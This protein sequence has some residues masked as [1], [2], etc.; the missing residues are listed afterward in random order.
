MTFLAAG[1][2][3]Y[4]APAFFTIKYDNTANVALVQPATGAKNAQ[5]VLLSNIVASASTSTGSTPE[6]VVTHIKTPEQVRGIYMSQCVVG[7]RSF[8]EKLVNVADTTEV[9]SIVIDIKDYSGRIS[10]SS[11]NPAISGSTSDTCGAKDMVAFIDELHKKNIY[12]IGRITVFQDPY[13]TKLHP[14]LAVRKRSDG[15]VWKDRKG[16]AFIDVGAKPFWDYIV[17][18][19]KEAY[20]K[21]FDELNFDYIRFPSDGDMADTDYTLSVDKGFS[22][23]VALEKFFTYLREQLEPTGVVM[24]ADLFGMTTVNH[25][26]L[27]IGQVLERALPHFDFVDPMVYPSHYPPK[28]NGWPDPNK[29]PYGVVY[30]SM[31]T[32]VE[33]ANE[34]DRIAAGLPAK[35]GMV[36]QTIAGPISTTTTTSSSTSG[37]TVAEIAEREAKFVPQSYKKLRPWLQDFDYG[38]NYDVPE[39]QAQKKATYDSGLDSWLMWAPSNIYTVGALEAESSSNFGL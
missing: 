39:I 19:G 16:L 29:Q 15:G 12:V 6:I 11:N 31:S 9:N 35:K 38:G 5:N 14:E 34:M 26:D 1:Y 7:S 13:M 36:A 18:I 37:S 4:A 20:D 22:K 21:G 2:A 23:P 17:T 3:V 10:F 33:R 28:F 24:S 30:Y 8:R 25:D 32:A 27:G